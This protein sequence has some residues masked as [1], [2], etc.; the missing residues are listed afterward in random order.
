M[1]K[2]G[3]CLMALLMLAAVAVSGTLYA[4]YKMGYE[5]VGTTAESVTIKKIGNSKKITVPDT[6]GK[7]EPGDGVA[8]D[9]KKNKIRKAMGGC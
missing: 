8:Y 4:A 6:S 3:I 7:Y 2:C 5:V 9:A 1:K